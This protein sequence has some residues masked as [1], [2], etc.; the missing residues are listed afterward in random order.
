MSEAFDREIDVKAIAFVGVGLT[1]LMVVPALIVWGL[2][3]GL[4]DRQAAAD[5]PPPVLLEARR[6]AAVPGP[7]LQ[8]DPFHEIAEVI[9]TEAATLDGWGWSDEG[10]GLARIPI[11]RAMELYL[12]GARA[13]APAVIEPTVAAEGAS[14]E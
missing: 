1:L 7:L 9:R 13:G 6:P 12:E 11:G 2:S 8:T 5:P 3:I 4:R 14:A 10:L